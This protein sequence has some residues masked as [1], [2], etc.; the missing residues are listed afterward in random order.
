VCPYAHVLHCLDRYVPMALSSTKGR[1]I[2]DFVGSSIVRFNT[3]FMYCVAAIILLVLLMKARPILLGNPIGELLFSSA[4]YPGKGEFGLYVFIVSSLEVSL[5]AMALAL[6]MCLLST[7]YIS[8]YSPKR[9][10]AIFRLFIDILAGIPSVIFGL[11]GILVIVPIVDAV[12]GL[13][14]KP[15]SGY[16]LL[17][18]GI[19]LA[20]MVIPII[21]SISTEVLMA[22]PLEVRESALSLGATRWETVKYVVLRKSFKGLFAAVIL[23]FSRAFGETIAVLMVVGNVVKLPS[24]L[25]DPAYPLPALIAN[26]YGEMMS[27]PL[28]DSALLLAALVLMLVVGG[29][30]LTANTILLRVTG[31]DR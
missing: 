16:S 14:N 17:A 27:I 7:I 21:I 10:Q 18:G 2:R 25:L 31:K 15:T 12:G 23:A 29:V 28:Y 22:V 26:N 1:K 11:F 19:I 24:S 9:L 20:I 4:W 8:E 3:F 30:S 13:L 6:P 5:L